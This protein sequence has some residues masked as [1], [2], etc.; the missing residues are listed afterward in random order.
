MSYIQTT[1]PVFTSAWIH[2]KYFKE[3]ISFLVSFHHT[4]IV[5]VFVHQVTFLKSFY[6]ENHPSKYY[7][8]LLVLFILRNTTLFFLLS[9]HILTHFLKKLK[10]NKHVQYAGSKYSV[11]TKHFIPVLLKSWTC[12]YAQLKLLLESNVFNCMWYR[13]LTIKITC[14][15][16]HTNLISQCYLYIL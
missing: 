2:T 7:M 9:S 15:V 13:Y 12:I 5:F 8:E 16:N 10:S 6:A 3:E 11:S 1:I 14:V 4:C